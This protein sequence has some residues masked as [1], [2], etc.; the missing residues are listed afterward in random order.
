MNNE[1]VI[2]GCKPM[3]ICDGEWN[4]PDENMGDESSKPVYKS[5]YLERKRLEAI[6][7]LGNKWVLHKEYAGKVNWRA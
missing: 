7:Y 2:N 5:N 4:Y 1:F 6:A 3:A